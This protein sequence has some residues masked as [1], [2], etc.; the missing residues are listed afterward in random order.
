MLF[1]FKVNYFT[2]SKFPSAFHLGDTVAIYN[3]I[4]NIKGSNNFYSSDICTCC[5]NNVLDTFKVL[6]DHFLKINVRKENNKELMP[7]WFKK[8]IGQRPI[9]SQYKSESSKY[10]TFQ[11]DSRSKGLKNPEWEEEFLS[12]S[13]NWKNLGDKTR[14]GIKV[15]SEKLYDKI[16]LL[17]NS[18]VYIGIDSGITHIACMLDIDVII[19]HDPKWDLRR[20]YQSS[21]NIFFISSPKELLKKMKQYE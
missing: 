8:Y 6:C 17:K 3:Q 12:I 18:R 15:E 14:K 9:Y 10:F 4:Q 20:F 19:L 16:K 5:G 7:F 2:N 1:P 21:S 11:L 13:N